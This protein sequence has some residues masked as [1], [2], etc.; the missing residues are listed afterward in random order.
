M[1]P[2][3]RAGAALADA[4]HLFIAA[5][6]GASADSGMLVF[7]QGRYIRKNLGY[8]DLPSNICRNIMHS[9]RTGFETSFLD[10][11]CLDVKYA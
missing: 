9:T 10:P 5:G 8:C 4:T 11:L 3:E 1:T 7:S 2:Y 6:A